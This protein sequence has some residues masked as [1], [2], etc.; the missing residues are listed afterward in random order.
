MVE[1]EN[2]H[3]ISPM[4]GCMLCM[5]RWRNCVDVDRLRLVCLLTATAF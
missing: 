5:D 4:A 3:S 1:E 2:K